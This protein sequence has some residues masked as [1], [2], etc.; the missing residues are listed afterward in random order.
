VLARLPPLPAWL[1]P[2]A[3]PKPEGEPDPQIRVGGP[4]RTLI[5]PFCC[6]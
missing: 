2:S 3:P 6:T 5:G 1:L 4:V